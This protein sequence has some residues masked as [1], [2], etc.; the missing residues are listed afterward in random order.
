M[1]GSVF[2]ATQ[3]RFGPWLVGGLLLGLCL[4][5]PASA[6]GK[7]SS[8][9][10]KEWVEGPIR[11]IIRKSEQ[12]A[13]KGLDDDRDRAL[14]IERFWS[15]RDPDPETLANPYRQLFWERVNQANDQFKDSSKPGWKTDRGKIYILYGAPN[16]M[17]EDPNLRTDG[18]A[19]GGMGVIRWIYEG[20][21]GERMDMDPIVVVP[22]V[23]DGSG[24]YKVSYD[25][26]LASVFFDPTI[27]EDKR[28]DFASR[29]REKYAGGGQVEPFGDARPREDAGGA[30]RRGGDPRACRD[31][32]VLRHRHGGGGGSQLLRW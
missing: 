24:E 9:N 12:K 17:H 26:A 21:P 18:I 8:V 27:F 16:E 10:L 15:R 2:L 28:N 22:F 7:S 6:K 30:A 29:M 14:F 4:A 13:F 25:P 5:T 23:R 31:L 20:R 32:A 11:Y 3:R 1:K 19:G